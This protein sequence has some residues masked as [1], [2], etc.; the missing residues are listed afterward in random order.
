MALEQTL[1][2]LQAQ[3]AQLQEMFLNLS[4]GQ[5]E[6]KTLLARGMIVGSPRND[7]GD[8]WEL[9][10]EVAILK[11]ELASQ[12]AL[13][14]D[15]AQKQEKLGV[16]VNQL[17]RNNQLGQTSKVEKQ[18]TAQPPSTQEDKGKAPLHASGSQTH[19]QPRQHQQGNRRKQNV[20]GR[21]FSETEIPSS[22]ILKRLLEV[23]LLTLKDPPRNPN[24]SAPT[25]H[26]NRRC[27]YHSYGPGH[28]T[29]DCWALKNKIQDLIDIGVLEFMPDGEMKILR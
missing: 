3:S 20:P 27:A 28:D 23:N 15:L 4:K 1:Q 19:Q 18:V 6:V 25:Y 10:I 16:L 22:F 2:G 14:Q 11:R 13:I 17:L 26:P 24:T 8:Q 12:R 5:E 29:D 7:R 21:R 9:H